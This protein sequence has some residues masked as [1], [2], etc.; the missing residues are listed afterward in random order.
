MVRILGTIPD[1]DTRYL[2]FLRVALCHADP[3]AAFSIIPGTDGLQVTIHP[4][5]PAF[6]DEIIKTT[7]EA[8]ARMNFKTVF[9]KSLAIQKNIS[10]Y[11]TLEETN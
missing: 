9:S 6:R 8:N 3:A 2:D 1:N 10:F 5:D 7:M 4:S 11:L